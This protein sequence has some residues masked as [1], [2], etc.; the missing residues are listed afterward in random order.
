MNNEIEELHRALEAAMAEVLKLRRENEDLQYRLT[1][2]RS[3]TAETT[4]FNVVDPV[5]DGPAEHDMSQ[6][7][8]RFEFHVHLP[9][10]LRAER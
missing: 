7:A 2:L 3:S 6:V 4:V 1:R 9:T 8:D 5:G 10:P